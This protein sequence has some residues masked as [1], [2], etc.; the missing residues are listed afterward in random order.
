MENGKSPADG[1]HRYH[2]DA[3]PAPEIEKWPPR[4]DVKVG[5]IGLA[6]FLIEEVLHYGFK[7]REVI[8]SRPC[9]YGTFSGPV[10]GFMPRPEFCVGCLRCTTEF[11]DFVT[12]SPNLARR[13]LGDEYFTFNQIDAI[14]YEVE[15][16]A[17]P[18]KGAGYRGKFGGQGWDGMWTDMSEIVRPTRDGIHGREF[19]STVVDIGYRPNALSFGPNGQPNGP[20]PQTFSIPLPMLFDAPPPSAANKTIWQITAA[21]AEAVGSVAILPL[22][23]MLQHGLKG[24]HIIPLVKPGEQFELD[25]IGYMPRLVLMDG[26][27]SNLHLA[28][29]RIFPQSLIGLRLPFGNDADL[30]EYVEQGVRVFHLLAD[31]HGR[32]GTGEFVLD[33]IR[34]AHR[35]FVDAGIRQE[36][37]LLGSGGIIAAEHIPKAIL[38]GLDAVVLDTPVLVALQAKFDS[39]T[40]DRQLA[41]FKLPR[42]LTVAWGRQRLMNLMASWRDQLLEIMGAMGLREVRRMRGEMGRAMFMIDLEKDA[43]AE[44]TGYDHNK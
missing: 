35:T 44:V 37:T 41:R 13:A 7:H 27:D 39:K 4:F 12:V 6:K 31:Y 28:V 43:F 24:E 8:M 18:V 14:A 40:N 23:A 38:C 42:N 26:W 11:P 9:L 29:Q 32:S 30:L 17:I 15:E 10:G 33:M 1:Y 3:Q 5:R 22:T 34:A 19:I 36:V 16:G 2:I 25:K 20:T 21:A